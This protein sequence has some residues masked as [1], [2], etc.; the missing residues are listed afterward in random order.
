MGATEP[1]QL[2][3]LRLA[4]TDHGRRIVDA[5]GNVTRLRGIAIGGWMNMENFINGYPGVEHSL[6]WIVGETLGP[7]T[8]KFFLDRLLD[9]YL[10]EDDFAFIKRL[11]ANVVRLA[12]NYRHFED[13]DRPFSYK[14]D[15]FRRMDQAIEW[16][17]RQGIYAIL[18]CTGSSCSMLCRAGRIPSGTPTTGTSTRCSGIS[19]IS[20]IG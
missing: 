9:H 6:R 13:D 19:R 1:A 10:T 2:S 11:G 3:P 18:A 16:C 17:A 4:A 8:G 14:E 5:E 20:R 15:G 7:S 12:F